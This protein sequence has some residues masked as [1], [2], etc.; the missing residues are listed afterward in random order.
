MSLG[1]EREIGDDPSDPERLLAGAFLAATCLL[2]LAYVFRYRIDS[3]EPQHLHVVWAG[4]GRVAV[5][6]ATAAA[7]GFSPFHPGSG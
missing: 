1:G 7:E 5:V 4:D 6:W 3:D 2:R